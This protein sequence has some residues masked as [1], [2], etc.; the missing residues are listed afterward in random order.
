MESYIV[1]DTESRVYIGHFIHLLGRYLSLSITLDRF[2]NKSFFLRQK[3]P[4][5]AT[6]CTG[7]QAAACVRYFPGQGQRASGRGQCWS[8]TQPQSLFFPHNILDALP[9]FQDE[10]YHSASI[11]N[12]SS[13]A[14]LTTNEAKE[15]ASPR[16]SSPLGTCCTSSDG[17]PLEPDQG[18]CNLSCYRSS[19]IC[20][21]AGSDYLPQHLLKPIL[22]DFSSCEDGQRD[23]LGNVTRT[24]K[25][26]P[27]PPRHTWRD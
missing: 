23:R 11:V 26:T 4:D 25:L 5:V 24:A 2:H 7:K 14:R 17:I 13:R 16:T 1:W 20:I 22:S 9:S 10:V 27:P 12:L 19:S 6:A 21:T 8:A 3:M 15:C 18:T